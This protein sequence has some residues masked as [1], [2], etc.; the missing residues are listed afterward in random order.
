[1]QSFF[2]YTPCTLGVIFLMLAIP[3]LFDNIGRAE[4]LKRASLIPCR[5]G[6]V[7]LEQEYPGC[8][9]QM[10]SCSMALRSSSSKLGTAS[11]DEYAS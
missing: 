3:R 5:I 2:A 1:M 10:F 11:A 7:L 9:V 6:F 4:D 8:A